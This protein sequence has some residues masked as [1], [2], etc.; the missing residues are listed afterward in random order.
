MLACITHIDTIVDV[1]NMSDHVP[2]KLSVDISI[3]NLQNVTQRQFISKPKWNSATDIMI[4]NYKSKLDSLLLK[5]Q[6]PFDVLHCTVISCCKHDYVIEQLYNNI[7]TV[8]LRAAELSILFTQ[9]NKVKHKQKTVG[10]SKHV[11]PCRDEALRW[12]RIWKSNGQPRA[13]YI[14]E[15]RKCTRRNYHS[16]Q[17]YNERRQ[18]VLRNQK[19]AVSFLGSN[20]KKYWQEINK[21]RGRSRKT[22]SIIEDFSANIDIANCFAEKYKHLFNSVCTNYTQLTELY[23]NVCLDTSNYCLQLIVIIDCKTHCHSI[24]YNDVLHA[25]KCL[26]SAKSDGFE[27]LTSDYFCKGTPLLYECMSFLFTS[28]IK[29][30]YSPAKFGI[31]TIIPIHKGAN[32]KLSECKNYRA[33]ALSSMFSKILDNCIVLRQSDILESDPLQFAYKAKASTIQCTAVII[34]TINY[35]I[36]NNCGVYMCMLDAS[37]AFD[38]VDL[39]TLFSKLRQ[40]KICPMI[41]RFLM[42]SY[43]NQFLR[44]NWNGEHSSMFSVSNGVK[45]GGVL[46]PIL[47]NVYLDDLIQDLKSNGVGC[48]INGHFAGCFV[49]ADDITL[50]APSSEALHSMLNICD[51]YAKSHNILFNTRKTKCMYFNKSKDIPY[52]NEI[53]FMGQKIDFVEKCKFLGSVLCKDILDRD[54]N[55]TIHTFYRKYNEIKLDFSMLSS[56]LKSKLIDTYCMDLYGSNLWN[57]ASGYVNKLYTAWRKA[58]RSIWKLPYITHCKFIHVINDTLPVDIILEKRCIKF[59]WSLIHSENVIVKS[60]ISSA[61]SSKHSVLGENYRYFSYKYNIT[62]YT[63]LCTL[64]KVLHCINDYV[65]CNVYNYEHGYLIRELCIDRDSYEHV[66]LTSMEMSQMIEYICTI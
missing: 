50:I 20:K 40:R 35:Y 57:F 22:A 33:I 14:F 23:N 42:K 38:R 9:P 39:Y 59:I 13:G 27:G 61:I 1:E 26:K 44:V 2:L 4:T 43:K 24:S 19:V 32:L 11:K 34:D 66:I 51:V 58:I 25:I 7:I 45:Q 60:V 56:E 16:S 30:N 65:S 8:L 28:M 52:D 15:M 37:K 18:N 17:K 6:L 55:S 62:P 31:S 47:F 36:N 12:N 64:P 21:I 41:L 54:I 3:N 53:Y 49:Y 63:W 10:W 48:H 5:L 46:S 29:H